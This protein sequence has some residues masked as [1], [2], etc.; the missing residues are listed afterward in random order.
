MTVFANDRDNISEKGF[1]FGYTTLVWINILVQ[2]SG[3]LLVAVV[4]K[5]ADN[6]LKGFAT[7]A[8][9]ILSCVASVYLFNTQID[10][11]FGMG[12]LLV[13]VSVF[14][15][16][17]TPKSAAQLL[18]ITTSPATTTNPTHSTTKFSN[19]TTSTNI[20]ADDDEMARRAD[21][22]LIKYSSGNMIEHE[23][24]RSTS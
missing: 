18:P 14:L 3:G 16:S 21:F 17:Y 4:I 7:S 2:S 9:I 15:Y 13:V 10:F 22:E 11:L 23:I 24:R 1:F 12:T 6:I 20:D 19:T 8:A 5:Y